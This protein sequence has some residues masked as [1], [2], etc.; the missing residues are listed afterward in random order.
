MLTQKNQQNHPVKPDT[1][2]GIDFGTSKIAVVLI[3]PEKKKVLSTV[4][5]DTGADLPLDNSRL[6]EQDLQKI[7]KVLLEC[8]KSEHLRGKGRI[9]SIGITGQMHGVL[10]VDDEGRAVTNF[11]TWQDDRGNEDLGNGKTLLKEMREKGGDRALASG[12]G[13][14]TLYDW[15]IKK[16]NSAISKICTLSDYFGMLL[17]GNRYPLLDSTMAHSFGCYDPATD[18]WDYDYLSNLGID[19]RYFGEVLQPTSSIGVVANK[20]FTD[21]LGGGRMPVAVSMGDNQA[22]FLGSVRDHYGSILM[23][24]G[25][26][27]QISFALSHPEDA[28][29]MGDLID[30]YD[31][32][33]RPFVQ[34]SCLVA[35]NA[36]S[37][38]VVYRTLKEFFA[39]TGRILFGVSRFDALWENMASAAQKVEGAGGLDVYP[40]FAGKRSD[41]G[42]KG[43]IGGIDLNNFTPAHLIYGTLE[44][45]VR[46][47]RDMVDEKIFSKRNHLIGS[48]NGLRRNWVL[49]N[50]S[51]RVFQK[52]VQVP[53]HEEEAA[54]GAAINGAVAAG[55][56]GNFDEAGEIIQYEK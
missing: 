29:Q 25:T 24:I 1:I 33:V 53:L 31:V 44:G 15:V 35:G 40:L 56:Y 42:A 38:G 3:D 18:S 27:S 13:I 32:Y 12:Y 11:V 16:N 2:M 50:I 54:I 47:L 26:G 22:S 5:F 20:T 17:T 7:A 9:L 6:K 37:G 19:R 49:R 10:G 28:K 8:L 46:I 48:G 36:L 30:G 45:M 39:Q 52:D 55:V 34:N 4:S 51:S 23:N 14:V 41:P 43:C 21:L